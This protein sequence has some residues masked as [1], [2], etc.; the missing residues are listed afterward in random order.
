M[1][2]TPIDAPIKRGAKQKSFKWL[3]L[4]NVSVGTFMATLD[5]SIA[6][7]ALPTI[8]S[9][10][11]VPLHMVQWVVTAYLLTICA[12][13]P[14]VG[15]VSDIYG[16]G[17]LY[18]IGFLIFSAGSALCALS[19]SILMLIGTRIVQAIGASLLMANSQALV[20]T[21]FAATER[22]RAM[23]I[24]GTMVSLGSLTGP[25]VGGILIGV[26]GWSSI[27]WVN[28]PIGLIGF[29]AGLFILPKQRQKRAREPFDYPGSI[30]FM[31]GITVLLYSVSNAEIW[32]W[33]SI[34]TTIGLGSSILGL[35]L[36]YFR[37]R[38]FKFP[39]LD[40]S[41]YRI[42]IFTTGS[43]AAFLSFVSL[44]CITIMMPFFL[45]NVLHTTP[46]VTG[47]VMA[48][49]PLTMAVV[50]PFSGWLSDKIGPYVLTTAG[51]GVNAIGFILLNFL[52]SQ[53]SPWLVAAHLAIFGCGQGMFQSPNNSSIMGAVP[54]AKV[55]IAGGLNALTRNI[56]MIF[57]ISLSIS[58][59]SYRLHALTGHVNPLSIT[60]PS[61]QAFVAALHTVFWSAVFV[62][63]LGAIASSMRSKPNR[64]LT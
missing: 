7:V 3:V 60:T 64:V 50:A 1:E 24:T 27:F 62:C 54:R 25:A 41:L 56:G 58:V 61:A 52:S 10:L 55:G 30:L 35:T 45:Q 40:F 49:F 43:I 44:F 23:G 6:N 5:G 39:M 38:I 21:T 19:T 33:L 28:V 15:K 34:K 16:R 36:F 46:A 57:G 18:N 22:G 59:F 48:A 12:M 11:Q 63:I 29:V 47:Y 37:E 14:I 9:S 32:G 20:T 42:R 51:L 4:I 2:V 53:A 17:L 13:L 26:F 8:S 31:L